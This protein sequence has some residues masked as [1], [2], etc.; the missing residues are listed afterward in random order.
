MEHADAGRH[1]GRCRASLGAAALSHGRR[2]DRRPAALAAA[3]WCRP[4]WRCA[5]PAT[6]SCPMATPAARSWAA[7]R[8]PTIRRAGMSRPG[9]CAMPGRPTTTTGP[10]FNASVNGKRYWARYRRE[11][12]DAI[13][14]ARLI[15][16]QELSNYAARSANRLHAAAVDGGARAR[17]RRAAALAGAERL[18]AAQGR[19]LRLAL[20]RC[21]ATPT[22]GRCRSAATACASPRRAWSSRCGRTGGH[23]CRSR[24][25]WRCRANGSSARPTRSRPTAVLPTADG[26]RRSAPGARCWCAARDGRTG[27][28]SAS[29]SCC[30]IGG[31]SVSAWGR[32]R[33]REGLQGVPRQR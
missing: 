14:A 29:P 7:R 8:G 28:A 18:P 24:C 5:M 19:D 32:D 1:D 10:T 17:G 27:R 6:R 33:R 2:R 21:R 3:C 31:D 9:R 16:P 4:S 30:R 22:N 15:E 20:P 23:R 13:A 26:G 25:R 12:P 11:R